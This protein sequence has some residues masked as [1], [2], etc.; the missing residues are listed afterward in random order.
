MNLHPRSSLLACLAVSTVIAGCGQSEDQVTRTVVIEKTVPA[1]TADAPSHRRAHRMRPIAHPLVDYSG[2]TYA[3]RVPAGWRVDENQVDH[4]GYVRSSW[5]DPRD[6]DVSVLIDVSEGEAIPADAKA[7]S[8]MA[9]T[10]Q[11]SGYTEQVAGPATVA[12]LDGYKWIFSVDGDQRVDYFL[13]DCG[14]GVAVLGSAPPRRFRTF[15]STFARVANSVKVDCAEP[16]PEP[17]VEPE[18]ESEAAACHPSYEGACLDPSASDYDCEGGEGDGPNYTGPV[19]VIGPDVYDLD[20][21]G[22]GSGCDA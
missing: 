4:S 7:E 19:T 5:T 12:G 2:A 3:I 10:R 6:P 14:V 22:D 16:E 9:L 13:N 18:P 15:A 1:P 21:D 17:E 8:V 11:S 20:R